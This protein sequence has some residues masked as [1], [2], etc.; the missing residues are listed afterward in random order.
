MSQR[1]SIFPVYIKAEYDG[2]GRAFDGLTAEARKAVEDSRRVFE[3][4]FSQ[5]QQVVSKALSV[6]RNQG[7]SLDL[8]VEEYRR[9]AQE[10]EAYAIAS[11]EVSN[12]MQAQARSAG[13]LSK[14]DR[15]VAASARAAAIE[16]DKHAQELRALARAAELTQ[17]ELNKTASA[18][19]AVVAA[20]GRGTQANH[21]VVN[22][23][24]AVRQAT[25]QA[26]QQL[27]DVA[28]SLYSGQ[29]AAVV[30]AQQLPQL[31]FS[32][33]GLSDSANAT[34]RKIG[35]LAEFLSGPWGLAVGVAVGVLG[36]YIASL[37]S[38]GDA[39][40]KT[41]SATS[42]LKDKIDLSKNSYEALIAVV[43][44]Y[45]KS[46]E[47]TEALTYAAAKAA[48]VEAEKLL[49]KAKAKLA[50][51]E[52]Q[53]PTENALS[54]QDA[55][56]AMLGNQ[57]LISYYKKRIEGL[58]KDLRSSQ[59]TVA[60]LDVK[61]R[62]DP[63]VA[64]KRE[65]ERRIGIMAEEHKKGL[66]STQSYADERFKIEQDLARKLKALNEQTKRQ[67]S[68]APKLPPVTE[69]E[70]AG[71][72]GARRWGGK[73][74][75]A[76]NAAVGGAANSYHLTGQAIDLPLT[77]NGKPLTKE[78][79][80]AALEPAGIIIKE[81]HGPG[82]KGHSDH[83]H[84]A[85]DR[86]RASPDKMDEARQRAIAAAARETERLGRISD[87]A[88]EN[89]ARIG[90]EFDDQPRLI[91]RAN[92]AAAKLR[93]I[94]KEI[95]EQGRGA[96]GKSLVPR[97]DEIIAQAKV[98]E[99]AALD[100][101][102]RPMRDMLEAAREQEVLDN[103]RLNNLNSQAAVLERALGLKRATGRVTLEEVEAIRQI[104]AE[105]QRRGQELEKQAQAQRRNLEL[106]D[107][108][109]Q[110]LR[111]GIRDLLDGKGFNA[112]GD[113]FKRQFDA[114]K[115]ALAD[116]LSEALFDDVFRDQRLKI[117]GLDKVDEAGQK[118]AAK[119]M[120]IIAALE[121]YRVALR[122]TTTAM[123]GATSGGFAANDNHAGPA[124]TVM[125]RRTV[126]QEMR[127]L[128]NSL[129]R[130]V[131]GPKLADAI[132]GTLEKAMRGAAFGQAGAGLVL[133]KSGVNTG[134]AIGGMFGEAAFKKLGGS[135]FTK[136]G[137][138]GGPV[139]MMAGG[140]IG[141]LVG[142]LFGGGA[143]WGTS[144]VG[145]GTS[146]NN[147]GMKDGTATAAGSV[148]SAISRL[149]EQLGG[150]V[151]R[152]NV[153]IGQ[154]DGKWRVSTTGRTGKLE[155]KYSDV[156]NFGTEGAE[157]ALRFAI[158]DAIKD[159]AIQGISASAQRLLQK[160]SDDVEKAV[161]KALS[162]E[163][164]FTRLKRYT[165]PVGA[166]LDEL[167]KEF[168]KLRKTF[169][170]AGASAEEFAK[171]EQLYGIERANA[172]KEANERVVGS[173]RSLYEE[174]TIGNSALSLRDRKAEALAKYNPLAE[175]VRAGD[176][177]AYDDFAEAAR[178]LLEIERELSGSQSGY[179]S[180][181]DEVTRLT[182]STLDASDARA[183]ASASAPSPFAP[184]AAN[185]NPAVVLALG[186]LGNF[187]VDGLSGPLAAINQ[188]L[189]ALIVQGTL[190]GGAGGRDRANVSYY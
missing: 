74:S 158:A 71:L 10:A 42:Q 167:N 8:G 160:Y 66:R 156:T 176:V 24:Q 94:V 100:S 7:G 20:A 93:D 102:N 118:M 133:G 11:R 111:Q 183:N 89:V 34:Q 108:T 114:Y 101:V 187:I 124:I 84:I 70:V 189:G 169:E 98:A 44:E 52:I 46:L 190:G 166:A 130:S 146:G 181:L 154:M 184:P 175:R 82:D 3:Q 75:A 151:G 103:L 47:K 28:I 97:G 132:G 123:S 99:A 113:V 170:E 49:A 43:N 40:D 179:F 68:T 172:I 95:E 30:M 112:I 83:F 174:L 177:T 56:S 72:L 51:L 50:V 55:A 90:A 87:S 126:E 19:D 122:Q 104:V 128:G 165:D 96:D 63:A 159:G 144:V 9:A 2:S 91:D 142:K 92:A 6:P 13:N 26:G 58:E 31:A 164:V 163:S 64:L 140:I 69:A 117:L 178:A 80:R 173:L 15:I 129:M 4:G 153:S 145:G 134:S 162:F 188:N 150:D 22:S 65:A 39:A 152:Y 131:L 17:A 36:T 73:R 60:D 25:V 157:A 109:Q 106:L 12:A 53:D 141:G 110:N 78:G 76:R 115:D 29:Q 18:T 14:E 35:Q 27:Q 155:N 138:F 125:G 105:E 32:L 23:T 185:D 48:E 37:F 171:L 186:Q 180:L 119:V 136:L 86:R 161:E 148:S 59:L 21:Q 57:Q 168:T 107:R 16:A 135:L 1:S 139:G 77:I 121:E 137:A 41:G 54:N 85:F 67:T 62:L 116:Q 38:A 143:K 81:L 5:V 149:A 147:S 33:T 127:A 45:N 182:K 61:A 120:D 88:A 79:I